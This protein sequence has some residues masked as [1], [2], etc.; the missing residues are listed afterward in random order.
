MEK[1]KLFVKKNTDEK[2]D[3]R[4]LIERI[5]DWVTDMDNFPLV[6]YGIG[7][8]I[9][10]GCGYLLG[11][12]FGKSA[13]KAAQAAK[14]AKEF[15]KFLKCLD[16]EFKEMQPKYI[17]FDDLIKIDAIK[18][19]RPSLKITGLDIYGKPITK[20]I[21]TDVQTAKKLADDLGN[22]TEQIMIDFDAN[23]IADQ[24]RAAGMKNVQV[25]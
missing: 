4:K 11:H 13:G 8:G 21:G 14:D 20:I 9:G 23:A 19:T 5:G 25:F 2:N 10:L 17:D 18:G 24:M 1:I 15:D 12:T 7:I 22:I 6:T 3:E 16:E